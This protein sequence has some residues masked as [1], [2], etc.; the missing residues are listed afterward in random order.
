MRQRWQLD[1]NADER[2]ERYLVP[3]MF[4]PWAEDLVA[5]AAPEPGESVLDVACGSGVVARLV[6]QRVG[7]SGTVVGLDFNAGRLAVARSLPPVPGVAIQWREGD[8]L[9]LPFASCTFSLVCCQQGLQFFPDRLKA[10][11]E[12]HRVLTPGGR[13]ALNVWRSIQYNPG[14]AAMA[15]AL[16]R[17]VSPEAATFR[18]SPFAF[19]DGDELQ[20]VVAEAGFRDVVVRP[21]VKV[22]HF[23]SAEEFVRHYVSGVAPLAQMVAQATD[24]ARAAVLVAVSEA[25]RSYVGADGLAIPKASHLV[26]A[27]T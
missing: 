18:R 17:H 5:L 20:R 11:M 26:T 9:A 7:P 14:A 6:A 23:P 13:L 12:M 27:H 2:Y 15:Q 16:E 1:G 25:L 4:R 24:S 21:A 3:A 22:L 10:L 19:G 8:A